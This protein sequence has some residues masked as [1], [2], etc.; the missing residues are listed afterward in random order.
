MPHTS[1]P[2]PWDLHWRDEPQNIWL[3]KPRGL[4][5][6]H[7]KGCRE[8]R[9]CY[10]RA[11]ADTHPTTQCKSNS[12]KSAWTVSEEDSLANITC[13]PEGRGLLGLSPGTEALAGA[14][15]A[16]SFYLAGTAWCTR[17]LHCPLT[18]VCPA[19]EP[20]R[21]HAKTSR[22]TPALCSPNAQLK[23][24]GMHSHRGCFLPP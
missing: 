4:Y 14:I 3:G 19:P 21:S 22:H 16:L 6:G 24:T 23:P 9:F 2:N 13:L 12:L 7:Q 10:H 15:S 17:S 1:H 18:R 8:L 20:F 5:P 11:P